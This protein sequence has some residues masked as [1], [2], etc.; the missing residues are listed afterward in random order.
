[1]EER[2][3]RIS[4]LERITGL[5]RKTIH[6]YFRLGLLTPPIKTGKTMSYYDASH[7]SRLQE[8]KKLRREGYPLAMIPQA[9]AASEEGAGTGIAREE[10]QL[11][12]RQQ[13][14]A[15]AVE[16]FARKG[17]HQTKI[18]DIT[19]EL[20]LGHSTFYLYFP[21]KKALLMEC[22]DEVFQ[23]MFSNV[24]GEIK[25]IDNPIERLMKRGE[26]TL[27]AHPEFIDILQLLRTTMEEPG[28][29]QKRRQIYLSVVE[30]VKRDLEKA[31]ARSLIPEMDLNI[32][33]FLL[34]GFLES[35]ALLISL[36]PR[37]DV[38]QILDTL[39]HLVVSPDSAS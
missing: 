15:A 23:A 5:N 11:E 14:M 34:V 8:I 39:K 12:R 1:M 30:T 20:G 9:L 32:A 24:W 10:G 25:H 22:V 38:E 37:Y 28:L 16:I 13:I 19:K 36:E 33:A 26:V 35:A 27:K 2:P 18:S 7:V 4:D 3:L 17:Y 6:Y 29:E 21:S 31:R